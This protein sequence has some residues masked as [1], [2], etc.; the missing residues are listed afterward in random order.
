MK[1]ANPSEEMT[2]MT[3]DLNDGFVD[4]V[5]EL[6]A[7]LAK[8][9]EKIADLTAELL[10]KADPDGQEEEEAV[11]TED[12]M[13]KSLPEPVREMLAKAQSDAESARE[14]LRKAREAERDRV[15]V[16]KA[17]AWENLNID[18]NEFGVALRK[19]A[20]IS[21]DLATV[22]SD[23]F[24]A[25]NAQSE[26]AAIFSELGGAGQLQTGNAFGRVQGL[27]KAA[28]ASGDYRTIEQA[29]A[30][31]ISDNPELYNEYRA[32]KR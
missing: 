27:A 29:I 1:D 9:H 13:M 16:A 7:E 2:A 26:A 12:A 23:S 14:E 25:V 5:V 10:T 3:T 22:I 24:D 31:L 21:E 18:A 15:F 20:D 6:E 30:G 4:R 8:A 19:V 11:E 28:V 17:T 32:E